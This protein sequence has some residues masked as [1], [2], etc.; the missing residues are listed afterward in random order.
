MVLFTVAGPL[1]SVQIRKERAGDRGEKKENLTGLRLLFL[2]SSG[3]AGTW[4]KK[5]TKARR[6]FL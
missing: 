2:L 3:R 1:D 5:R 4:R 6:W